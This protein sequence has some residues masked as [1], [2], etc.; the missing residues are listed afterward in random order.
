MMLIFGLLLVGLI[1]LA[2]EIYMTPGATLFGMIG[3]AFFLASDWYAIQNFDSPWN[4]IYVVGSTALLIYL[5]F[6]ALKALQSKKVAL[7]SAITSKVNVLEE[8]IAEIGQVG[9][10]IT[11]LRPNGRA[12]FGEKKL[13]VFSLGDFISSGE[14]VQITKITSDKIFVKTT[15]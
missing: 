9:E 3:L 4:W 7:Q 5:T 15:N 14:A 8:D 11:D 10:T 1:F 13:E 12:L 6:M 2:V